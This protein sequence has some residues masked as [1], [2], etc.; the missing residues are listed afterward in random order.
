[1]AAT[2]SSLAETMALALRLSPLDKVRLLE[3]VASTL[4]RDMTAQSVVQVPNDGKWGQHL[5]AL[6]NQLDLSAWD[7]DQGEDP[8]EWVARQRRIQAQARIIIE[9]QY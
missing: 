1:M 3:Q 9:S 7:A 2:N 5:V 4:E 8:A 6:L